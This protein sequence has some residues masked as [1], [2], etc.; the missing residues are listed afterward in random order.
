MH[1]LLTEPLLLFCKFFI[2]RKKYIIPC[3]SGAERQ[4][5]TRTVF[6]TLEVVV[7]L[8]VDFVDAVNVV[9]HPAEDE[10]AHA[11]CD[12]DAHEQNLFAGVLSETL[13]D[14]LHLWTVN[15]TDKKKSKYNML[16]FVS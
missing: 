7:H 11:R 15:K 16:Y 14:V 6:V 1:S 5:R 2:A 13:L 12:T 9:C 4:C 10:T 8:Q 3:H